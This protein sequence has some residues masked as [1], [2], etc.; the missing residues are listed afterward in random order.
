M[1]FTFQ[2]A[3]NSK[4][5]SIMAKCLRKTIRKAHSRRSHI[6]GWVVILLALLL[7]FQTGEEGFTVTFRTVITWAAALVMFLALLFEDRLNGYFAS[8]RLLKGTELATA[9]FDT[10]MPDTFSSETA[11]G[12]SV[13]FYHKILLIAETKEYFVFIFSSSHAQIY[14]K[15]TLK[16]GSVNEF[17]QFLTERRGKS[18]LTIH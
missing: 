2:T 14:D 4:T 6:L 11:V 12:K 7:S 17:R 1:Q 18:P 8:K 13:F 15:S 9:F 10:E 5:L 16:G 3:Y